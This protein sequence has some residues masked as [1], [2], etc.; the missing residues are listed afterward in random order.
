MSL[1]WIGLAADVV[2]N[3]IIFATVRNTREE[4]LVFMKEQLP[5]ADT[6]F[7]VQLTTDMPQ[8]YH[9]VATWFRQGCRI[10]RKRIPK[11]LDRFRRILLMTLQNSNEIITERINRSEDS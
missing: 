11:E 2:N 10:P 4:A 7:A 6:Y 3:E 5:N 1:P 9:Q 8:F